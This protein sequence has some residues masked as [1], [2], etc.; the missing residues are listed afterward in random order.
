MSGDANVKLCIQHFLSPE[1]SPT[2]L[3]NLF[4]KNVI[5]I[6]TLNH[7]YLWWG[8]TP[9]GLSYKAFNFPSHPDH[10]YIWFRVGI[11]IT[12]LKNRFPSG[13][14]LSSGDKKC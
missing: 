4:F 14:G 3:G 8:M 1:L 13:V 12:F 2:P 5:E 9:H 11:S 7:I 10:K 6:P